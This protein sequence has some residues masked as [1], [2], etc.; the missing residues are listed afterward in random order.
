MFLEIVSPEATLFAGEVV[1]VTVPGLNGEFQMLSNHAPIVSLLQQGEVKIEG[2]IVLEEEY[3]SRF[4]S[5]SK[6]KTILAISSGTVEMKDNKVI[7]LA[8]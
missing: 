5:D 3:E 4:T 6:G 7:V 1:S 2:D 8:D